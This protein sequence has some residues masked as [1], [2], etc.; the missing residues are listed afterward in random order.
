LENILGAFAVTSRRL[1]TPLRKPN[2]KKSATLMYAT[3]ELVSVF[4]AM[5]EH[6]LSRTDPRRE[7]PLFKKLSSVTMDRSLN[8]T[9]WGIIRGML[10]LPNDPCPVVQDVRDTVM[11]EAV[12]TA[13]V[14]NTTAVIHSTD[15]TDD[16]VAPIAGGMLINEEQVMFIVDMVDEDLADVVETQARS[17]QPKKYR[18]KKWEPK[19][20]QIVAPTVDDPVSIDLVEIATERHLHQ[21]DENR[22][23]STRTVPFGAR[24]VS[25]IRCEGHVSCFEIMEQLV[26]LHQPPSTEYIEPRCV[27]LHRLVDG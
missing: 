23:L 11:E 3:E 2:P 27:P 13:D 22:L 10:V 12:D 21:K 4:R 8:G 26:D 6:L 5:D 14:P 24:P 16:D 19:V 18:T 17:P 1:S 25:V 20:I 15:E 9:E 7:N